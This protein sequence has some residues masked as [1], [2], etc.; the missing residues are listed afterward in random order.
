VVLYPGAGGG[1][2]GEGEN[3]PRGAVV[4]YHVDADLSDDGAE[5]VKIEVLDAAG[6]VLRTLSSQE[7]EPAAPNPFLR[8]FPEFATPRKLDAER[9][10]NR[11]VWDL[12][13]PDAELV[14]DAVLWGNAAGPEV[15]PGEYR[16]RLSRG[17]GE[18][19][20]ASF[21]VLADPRL[22]LAPDDA[23]ERFRLSRQVHGAVSR[24]HRALRALRDV[25]SQVADVT[26]RLDPDAEDEALRAAA[27]AVRE[28]LEGIE[29][30]L[31]QPKAKAVQDVLNFPPQ[32]DNQLLYLYGNVETAEGRPTA[33]AFERF[34]QLSGELDA[35]LAELDAALANELAAFNEAAA[36][37]DA[38][39]VVLGDA[40]WR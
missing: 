22:E 4:H 3:P 6:E 10:L 8:Y 16:V 24:A 20:E 34:E 2:Q 35:L 11:W 19:Q 9:G 30:R 1:G 5:E 28:R 14:D 32:L 27:D 26:A 17:G 39:R 23:A 13:L 25:R 7:E 15:P 33:G 36:G 18:A 40:D 37:A 29:A 31:T 38:P 21:R 12:R